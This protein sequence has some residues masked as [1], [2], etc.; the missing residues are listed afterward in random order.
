[1]LTVEHEQR[2]P[3][4]LL[5]SAEA[6]AASR[7]D[8]RPASSE[9]RG[10][11]LGVSRGA[12][13]GPSRLRPHRVGVPLSRVRQAHHQA[14]AAPSGWDSE[15]VRVSEDSASQ[16]VGL[17]AVKKTERKKSGTRARIAEAAKRIAPMDPA[18]VPSD[19]ECLRI[20]KGVLLAIALA[21]TNAEAM[22]A[23]WYLVEV[24]VRTRV[25]ARG[26]ASDGDTLS[27]DV[28]RALLAEDPTLM[29]L[30]RESGRGLQ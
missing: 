9:A 16:G 8:T 1:M 13:A 23:T 2:A 14:N 10:F 20:A 21:G 15:V 19:E 29:A 22:K 4:R 18:M 26:A 11:S 24:I 27:P 12:R 6:G 25:E 28:A 7:G 17:V 30:A 5:A 3:L